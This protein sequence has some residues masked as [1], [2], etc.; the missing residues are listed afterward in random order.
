[1]DELFVTINTW[2][3]GGTAL[4]ALGCL[5]WGMVSV[6]FSPCHLASIPLIVGY[7]GG[8]ERLVEG[9]AAAL[10]AVLFSTGLFAT[11]AAIG[12]VCSWLG[13]MMGAVGPYWT[14]LVGAILIWLALDMLGVAQCSLSGGLM[15]RLKVRGAGGAFLLGLAYGI[16]SGS[17][18]FGFIAPILALITI[19]GE[20]VRGVLFIVLFGLGHC[21]PIAVAG[22]STA[23]VRRLLANNSWQ[24]GSHLFR[25]IAGGLIAAMGVY[26]VLQPFWLA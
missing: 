1:M 19:Q 23:L 22:S 2:M 6:L 8:Q 16:L 21:I 10:Y 26:F 9:R 17:C 15:A 5:L 3:A 4:A 13:T 11:I 14:I 12:V 24:R 7:V 20:I 18:T 25:R